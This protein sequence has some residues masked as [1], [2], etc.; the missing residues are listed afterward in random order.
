MTSNIT[1]VDGVQSVTLADADWVIDLAEKAYGR[2]LD[3]DGC[4]DWIAEAIS[5]RNVFFRRTANVVGVA[6]LQY[7]FYDPNTARAHMLYL[8]A[9]NAGGWGAYKMLMLM[10]V[11]AKEA[12]A[13]SFHFGSNTKVDLGPFARRLARYGVVVDDPSWTRNF[14]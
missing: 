3:R 5:M 10:M 13:A 9:E 11:W 1:K 2:S 6:A 8:F 14:R 12:G 7:D 4:R